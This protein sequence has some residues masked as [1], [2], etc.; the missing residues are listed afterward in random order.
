MSSA[1]GLWRLQKYG[2]ITRVTQAPTLPGI[3]T[4]A[5]FYLAAALSE[6]RRLL[7]APESV[8]SALHDRRWLL[9]ATFLSD[10][11]HGAAWLN[12]DEIELGFPPIDWQHRDIACPALDD[13][14]EAVFARIEA[15]WQTK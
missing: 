12:V 14:S 3:D 2:N 9:R 10:L 7:I 11:S 1:R 8:I 6:R 4:P 13:F 5:A 15:H